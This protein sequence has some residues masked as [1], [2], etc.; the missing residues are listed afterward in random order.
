MQYY[1]TNFNFEQQLVNQNEIYEKKF[2]SSFWNYEFEYLFFF[3]FPNDV[4]NTPIIYSKDYINFLKNNFEIDAKIE[5][6][7]QSNYLYWWGD[8]ENFN[9]RKQLN[10][11]EFFWQFCCDHNIPYP[12]TVKDTQNLHKLGKKI[13]LRKK[14]GFSG[15]GLKI[16]E[17][18]N[19]NI[20]NPNYLAST[21]YCRVKDFG[22]VIKNDEVTFYINNVDKRGQYKGSRLIHANEIFIKDE[23]INS[24]K[25]L[26]EF[27]KSPIQV[28]GFI[29]SDGEIFFNE[30]NYRQSM[31]QA[32]ST[33]SDQYFSGRYLSLKIYRYRD[34]LKL[35]Q[36]TSSTIKITPIDNKIPYRFGLVVEL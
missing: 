21:Y 16:L 20:L 14:L 13:I 32:L 29:T 18:N 4:L 8:L 2:C 11:K 30:L 27:T 10:N 3:L 22:L 5:N 1:R 26:Q 35:K 12:K 28:D 36:G 9:L 23:Y 25:E 31:G 17:N 34:Y 24:F 15:Q 6:H 19:N 33:I 7:Q